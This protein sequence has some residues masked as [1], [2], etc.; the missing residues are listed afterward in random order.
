MKSYMLGALIAATA[1]LGD[2][3]GTAWEAAE[4][5]GRLDLAEVAC[6]SDSRLTNAVLDLA[7]GTDT[8]SPP[9]HVQRGLY[10]FYET[11]DFEEFGVHHRVEQNVPGRT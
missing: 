7:I 10:K 6:V 4:T 1:A 5:Y 3:P 9:G 2:M 11:N 8:I